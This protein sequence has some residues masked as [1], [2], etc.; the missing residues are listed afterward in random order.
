[1]TVPM[2]AW[3]RYRGHGWRATNEMAAAMLV[4][5]ALVLALLATGAMTDPHGLLM[6]E[7]SLMFPAML[8]AMLLRIDEYADHHHHPRPA[9]TA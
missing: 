8:G 5:T 7:H 3:M 9:A 6:V 4:P 1:M 2:A